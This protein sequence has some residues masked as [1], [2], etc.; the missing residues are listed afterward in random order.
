MFNFFET[1][2]LKRKIKEQEEMIDRR[3]DDINNLQFRVKQLEQEKIDSIKNDVNTSE[4]KIDWNKMDAFSIERM[5]DH[6]SAYT[7]IGY[8]MTDEHNVKHV[9]EWKFYCSQE[10]HNKLAE[11][12]NGTPKKTNSSVR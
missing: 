3:D 7:V 6:Q 4:F 11:E 1:A 5:G 8:Y 2:Q 12:F 9:H 10:Q